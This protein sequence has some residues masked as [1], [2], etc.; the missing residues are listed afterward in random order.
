MSSLAGDRHTIHGPE[1][2]QVIRMKF[3]KKTIAYRVTDPV[4]KLCSFYRG[5]LRNVLVFS[6][7]KH[8]TTRTPISRNSYFW[9]T[10]AF[11]VQS[12]LL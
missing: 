3:R 10:H 1:V 12:A 8:K 7:Q 6:V 9:T 2:T 4:F 5:V 11:L